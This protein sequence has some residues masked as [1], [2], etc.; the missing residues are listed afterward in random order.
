MAMIAE[1]TAPKIGTKFRS[2]WAEVVDN[3]NDR[4]EK[5]STASFCLLKVSHAS[6]DHTSSPARWISQH[7]TRSTTSRRRPDSLRPGSVPRIPQRQRSHFRGAKQACYTLLALL[8]LIKELA[9]LCPKLGKFPF[10]LL[11]AVGNLIELALPCGK[12]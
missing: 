8:S 11:R 10:P 4:P 7:H 9:I 3:T 6:F 12:T 5:F 1:V 2:I